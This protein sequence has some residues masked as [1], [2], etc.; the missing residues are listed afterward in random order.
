MKKN[1]LNTSYWEN[2]YSN[3]D[4]G[5][6]IGYPSY[7]IKTYIDQLKDKTKKILI[8][9]AG[10]SYEAEY[11]WNQGFK[12]VY[13]AD[14]AESPLENFKSRVSDFPENQ[15]LHQDFFNL[16]IKFDLVIEQTFFCALDPNKRKKYVEKMN[17]LIKTN[18]KIVGLFFNFPLTQTEPPFGGSLK[19]YRLLFEQKFKIKVLEPSINSIKERQGKELFFIFEK[20][21]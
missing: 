3:N 16:K 12:N 14:I 10:K 11:L 17:Q 4:I 7:P 2:R 21:Q 9:G 13:V 18:G 5:W 8:P 6:D 20:L 1:D 19:E 15:L